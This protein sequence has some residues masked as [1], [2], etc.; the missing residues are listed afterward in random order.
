MFV[1]RSRDII[2]VIEE[3]DKEHKIYEP[4][5]YEIYDTEKHEI[6]Y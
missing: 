2:T 6:I 1:I 4:N 3:L 5:F